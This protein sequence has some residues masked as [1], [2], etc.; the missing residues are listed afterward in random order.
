MTKLHGLETFFYGTAVVYVP[1]GP[2]NPSLDSID[3]IEGVVSILLILLTLL[4]IRFFSTNDYV[5]TGPEADCGIVVQPI[6]L[7]RR[8]GPLAHF[9]A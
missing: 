5:N 1:W 6:K 7:H 8:P 4:Y 9:S 3:L 2:N